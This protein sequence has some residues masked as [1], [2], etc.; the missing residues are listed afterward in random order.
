MDI[1]SIIPAIDTNVLNEE[2]ASAI[3]E[4]F[5][6]AVN[7]KVNAQV[8]LQVEGALS[9]QDEE[10]ASKLG[11]LLEA[12]DADHSEK[13]KKVVNAINENHASKLIKIVNFYKKALNE[14]AETFS[15]K[16]V[17]QI[18]NF[19]DAN[20]SKSIP[21]A[22]LEEAVANKTAIK[23][24]EQIKKII[25]FDPATLNEDVKSLI[26]QGK[27]KIEDL[28]EELNVSYKENIDLHEQLN[29][30]KG[31]LILEQKTKGMPT[32][33]K[34]YISKLL[35]DKPASYIEENFKFVVEM[36][37]REEKDLSGKL[38]EEAKQSAVSKNAKVPSSKIISESTVVNRENTPVNRYLTALQDIR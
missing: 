27:K 34:E 36:F 26:T 5:E 29:D 38:V 23:Q 18:S 3:A 24:L 15:E 31:A 19:L 17:N 7:E 32:S 37:E 6:I 22:E 16:V 1:S 14:K 35:S 28:H 8:E 13:L 10:H 2:A 30:L 20:L 25:S 33:K 21:H 12:I 4:A 11:K 9:K